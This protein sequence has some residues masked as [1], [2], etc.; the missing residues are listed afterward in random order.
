MLV[1]NLQHGTATV[2]LKKQLFFGEARILAGGNTSDGE[3][4][5][6]PVNQKTKH[7]FCMKNKSG[8]H[9]WNFFRISSGA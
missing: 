3:R 5:P 9:A 1:C 6:K 2:P 7:V 8:N 4:A